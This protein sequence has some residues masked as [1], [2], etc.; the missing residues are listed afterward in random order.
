LNPLGRR[1]TIQS[2]NPAYADWPD[3]GLDKVNCIGRVI[4]SGRRIV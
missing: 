2:D 1:V 4:W 3:C